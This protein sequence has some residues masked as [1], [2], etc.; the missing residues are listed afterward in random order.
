MREDAKAKLAGKKGFSKIDFKSTFWQLELAPESR[1]LTTFQL[2]D[3]L[4]RCKRLT[5]FF[6]YYY[7]CY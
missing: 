2:D 1:Y 5:S 4:F 7:L 6:H 3:R